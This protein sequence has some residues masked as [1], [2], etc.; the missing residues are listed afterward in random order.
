MGN[1]MYCPTRALGSPESAFPE[2]C[3]D[4]WFSQ[5]LYGH[6]A[7]LGLPTPA[8]TNFSIVRPYTWCWVDGSGFTDGKPSTLRVLPSRVSWRTAPEYLVAFSSLLEPGPHHDFLMP[9]SGH[10]HHHRHPLRLSRVGLGQPPKFLVMWTPQDR[11]EK[12]QT[13]WMIAQS[14]HST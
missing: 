10:I 11:T 4:S 8:E 2:Q 12:T 6:S 1:P 13:Y 14:T 5:L 9:K 7:L 3:E